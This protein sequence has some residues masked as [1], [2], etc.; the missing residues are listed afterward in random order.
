MRKMVANSFESSPID[1]FKYEKTITEI[2]Y[3]SRFNLIK[4]K[5]KEFPL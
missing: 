2:L 3:D 1:E 5:I 4:I